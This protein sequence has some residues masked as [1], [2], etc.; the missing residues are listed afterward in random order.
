MYSHSLTRHVGDEWLVT[1]EETE[2]YIP[3]VTEV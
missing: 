3:D 1:D 2:C